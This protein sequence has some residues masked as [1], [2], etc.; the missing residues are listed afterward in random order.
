MKVGSEIKSCAFVQL[1]VNCDAGKVSDKVCMV[2]NTPTSGKSV[3]PLLAYRQD[4]MGFFFFLSHNSH[5]T[6]NL[7]F[8]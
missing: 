1:M 7:D 4:V 6:L 3:D 2:L 5:D 8:F